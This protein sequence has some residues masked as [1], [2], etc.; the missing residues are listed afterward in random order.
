MAVMDA[1]QFVSLYS[2]TM[3]ETRDLLDRVADNGSV[4]L[5]PG[6]PALA[7]FYAFDELIQGLYATWQDR[8]A[9]IRQVLDS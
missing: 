8:E 5:K 2:A 7:V 3:T 6:S 4:T 9:A 1:E